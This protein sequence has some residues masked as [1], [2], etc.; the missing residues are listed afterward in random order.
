M[1]PKIAGT[2]PHLTAKDA[3]FLSPHKFPGGPSTPGVLLVKR[4]LVASNAPVAPGGG[5][6]FYVSRTQHRLV[7][8]EEQDDAWVVPTA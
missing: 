4:D 7:C 3:V 5:T 6:V 2:A 1:N 8:Y